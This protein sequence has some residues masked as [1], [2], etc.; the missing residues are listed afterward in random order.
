MKLFHSG[1]TA[2][3]ISD[4]CTQLWLEALPGPSFGNVAAILAVWAVLATGS[5]FQLL[6]SPDVCNHPVTSVEIYQHLS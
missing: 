6:Q 1:E 2:P 5:Q 4:V 3:Y